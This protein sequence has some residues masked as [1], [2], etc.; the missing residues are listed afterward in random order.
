MNGHGRL[1]EAGSRVWELLDA[2]DTSSTS[3]TMSCPSSGA[4]TAFHTKLGQSSVPQAQKVYVQDRLREAGSKVWELLEAGG[5]FYVCG[6]AGGMAPA[7][8][9]ALLDV[10]A[11]HQVGTPYKL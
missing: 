3:A 7:V 4:P 6:D 1:R 11:Q 9:E 2:G 8:Q 5:H 10:I